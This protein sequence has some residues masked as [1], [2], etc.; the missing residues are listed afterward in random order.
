[1]VTPSRIP[2]LLEQHT[3]LD[4]RG[5]DRLYL[6]AYQPSLQTAGS[7][8]YF[9]RNHRQHR[10]ASTSLREPMTRDFVRSIEQF[11]QQAALSI[12]TFPNDQRKETIAQKNG[13]SWRKLASWPKACT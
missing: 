8:V 4:L 6:K 7:V 3:T 2:R 10:F 11:A 5:I 12:E 1:M 13:R 9:F